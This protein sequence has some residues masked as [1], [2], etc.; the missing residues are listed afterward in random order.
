MHYK[1]LTSDE[2]H[3]PEG[4]VLN[5]LKDLIGNLTVRGIFHIPRDNNKIAQNPA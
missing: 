3:G 5:E 1:P 2:F 4:L